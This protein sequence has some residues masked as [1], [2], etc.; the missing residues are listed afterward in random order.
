MNNMYGVPMP[1]GTAMGPSAMPSTAP[2]YNLGQSSMSTVGGAPP[3]AGAMSPTYAA[4]HAIQSGLGAV[5][6]MAASPGDLVGRMAGAMAPRTVGNNGFGVHPE[7]THDQIADYLLPK[8]KQ[9]E[10]SNDYT[11]YIGKKD[12]QPFSMTHTASGGYGYTNGTWNNYAGYPRAMDAPPEVQDRRMKEDLSAAL[13]RFQGDPFKVVANHYYPRWAG[14]PTKWDQVP[15]NK[16]G[17]PIPGAQTIRQYIESVLPPD[18]VG[19]YMSA[20]VPAPQL[21][22]AGSM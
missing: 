22:N 9:V 19:K 5:G 15:T 20:A 18:R 13:H 14:D 10:S 6:A 1:S 7:V 4:G 17:Q 12:K 21:S 11:N 16:Y 2:M 3:A 8:F